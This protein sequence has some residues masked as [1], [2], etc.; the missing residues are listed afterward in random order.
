[1][2]TAQPSFILYGSGGIHMTHER[3]PEKIKRKPSLIVRDCL[4]FIGASFRLNEEEKRILNSKFIKDNE[5]GN[6]CAYCQ[7]VY[8]NFVTPSSNKLFYAIE[9]HGFPTIA[10][11]LEHLEENSGPKTYKATVLPIISIRELMLHYGIAFDEGDS[12]V[13]IRLCDLPVVMCKFAYNYK[14]NYPKM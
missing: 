10:S 5:P 1:L 14:I 7:N 6:F 2:T 11:G 12:K 13:I 9:A 8:L 4:K 3:Y